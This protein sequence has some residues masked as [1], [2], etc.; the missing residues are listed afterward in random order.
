MVF[1]APSGLEGNGVVC[2][3]C[4]TLLKVPA[5]KDITKTIEVVEKASKSAD[6]EPSP[7]ESSKIRKKR[8]S[9]SVEDEFGGGD[10]QGSDYSLKL[11]L[12]L[13]AL[14]LIALGGIAYMFLR[15]SKEF[16]PNIASSEEKVKSVGENEGDTVS[17]EDN[18]IFDP[19]NKHDMARVESF[20][21][22]W[23][24]AKTVE[25]R[26][27]LVRPVD[28]IKEK[29]E[30]FYELFP[31]TNSELKEL[32]GVRDLISLRGYVAYTCL[33]EDYATSS[34]IISYTKDKMLLDWE[35]FIAY[36]D[37]TLAELADKKPTEPVKIRAVAS[38]GQYYNNN[39]NDE[40]IW[41]AVILENP[42]EEDIIYGYVKINSA[43]EQIMF[44]FGK[45]ATQSVIIEVK[46]L[47]NEENGNQVVI[48][49]V[50]QSGWL[51]R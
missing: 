4:E 40:S 31:S 33:T 18:Y 35:S 24:S 2:P 11:I 9:H 14:S 37:M 6:L 10:F 36:S 20:L 34:G 41:R 29:M 22:E 49:K 48:D 5:E 43:N 23:Y 16:P 15:P 13:L 19:R 51:V 21:K 28:G 26:L 8:S 46:Y 27:K 30:R 7:E 42:N 1:C 44:N 38:A 47:P 12:P 25:E 3:G 50:I 39:F 17:E 32:S 45:S